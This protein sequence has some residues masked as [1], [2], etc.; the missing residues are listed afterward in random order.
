M[1]KA[2]KKHVFFFSIFFDV[3]SGFL[4]LALGVLGLRYTFVGSSSGA[5][6]SRVAMEAERKF[7]VGVLAQS[8][9]WLFFVVF[10]FFGFSMVFRWFFNGFSMVN[11]V[12][13]S[14]LLR[15]SF[16]F[17][18][19]VSVFFWFLFLFS[20]VLENDDSC[21][22]PKNKFVFPC[23]SLFFICSVSKCWNTFEIG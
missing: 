15:R 8:F 18:K 7:I 1:I 22:R 6:S 3:G 19:N 12:L 5:R 4:L 11:T 10:F 9:R 17:L 13:I 20:G 23:F 14:R 21:A 16:V 2:W